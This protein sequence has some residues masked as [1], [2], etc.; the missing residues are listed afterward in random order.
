MKKDKNVLVEFFSSVQLSLFTFFVL[1]IA[2]IIGTII[3]Q[4]KE[5][6]FYVAEYGPKLTR[7]FEILDIPDMY[8]SWWFVSL[9]VLLSL[10]LIVCTFERLPKVW[11]MVV[12][13]NLDTSRERLERQSQRQSFLVANDSGDAVAAVRGIL[14]KFGG[15]LQE[16]ADGEAT[17]LFTQKGAWTRL[18]VYV[19]H[20]SVLLIF[21]GA[22][23]G[24][25][26]GYKGSVM[27]PE[28]EASGFV[29]EFGTNRPIDMGFQV[30]CDRFDVSFY[31][32]GA[33]KEFRSALTV[34]KDG[35]DVL[36]KSIVVNDPLDYEGLT[37]YQASY[38]PYNQLVVQLANDGS[39]A[40]ETFLLSPREE[41]PW[42][43]EGVSFGII[44]IEGSDRSGYRYKVWFSDGKSEPVTFWATAD[45]AAKVELP[46]A[47]YSLSLKRRFATGLQVAKDPGVWY[48]YAGCTAMLL[49]L[50]VAFFLSHQR[51][52]VYIAREDGATRILLC[53]TANKNRLGF[54]RDFEALA[55]QFKHSDRLTLT[56][57]KS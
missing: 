25:V 56:E 36:S 38:E 4:N 2:S 18:G 29:Y 12:M 9:L 54:E 22:I 43:A 33:P 1:A 39:K 32:T 48:V 6:S 3:P 5:P 31:D 35:K 47:T 7:L 40:K 41:T 16:G 57:E 21:A 46:S 53:G 8:N 10:N 37:F 26:Y 23:I 30:R 42:A 55:D 44:N 50:L 14:T 52:W 15:R 19:V 28:G 13:D 20:L 49:G 11:R 45:Q 24:S 17:L 51:I 34:V 27:I